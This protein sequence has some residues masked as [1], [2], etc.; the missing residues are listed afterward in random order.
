MLTNFI[1]SRV[2]EV[3]QDL[4]SLHSFKGEPEIV[5]HF[6]LSSNMKQP[7]QGERCVFGSMGDVEKRNS[8]PLS[9]QGV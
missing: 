8:V 4:V 6:I 1:N 9:L 2:A 5:D 7:P 3:T